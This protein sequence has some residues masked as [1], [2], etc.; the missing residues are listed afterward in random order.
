[1]PAPRAPAAPA[2]AAPA[3]EAAPQPAAVQGRNPDIADQILNDVLGTF[4]R[5]D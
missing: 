1:V 4:G 2:A 3:R 5:R